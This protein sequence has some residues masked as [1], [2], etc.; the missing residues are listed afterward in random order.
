M[1]GEVGGDEDEDEGVGLLYQ[2]AEWTG[3]KDSASGFIMGEVGGD[4]DED[5]S[6]GLLYQVAECTG[7]KESA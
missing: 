6:V 1:M 2:V 4:E 7:R 3:R 5:E